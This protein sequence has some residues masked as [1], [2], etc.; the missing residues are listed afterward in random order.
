M[1]QP[2]ITKWGQTL[3]DLR[4]LSVESAHARTRERF[5]AL[6]MISSGQTVATRWAAEVGHTKETVLNW[7]HR[8][9][10]QGPEA[11]IYRRSG[12]RPP[13]LTRSRSSN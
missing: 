9:N 10:A 11:L 12:G 7:V 1:V 13:F 5:Q 4:K 8:Y 2:D 6:F 3:S